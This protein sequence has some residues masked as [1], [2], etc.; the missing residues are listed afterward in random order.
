MVVGVNSKGIDWISNQLNSLNSNVPML[1]LTKGLS[2]KNNKL[3][4]LTNLFK[5]SNVSGVAG[6]LFSKRFI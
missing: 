6:P 3:E 4:I 2:V 5:N 1:L